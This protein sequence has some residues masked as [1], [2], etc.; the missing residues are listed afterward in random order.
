M[1]D[2][3]STAGQTR[4]LGKLKVPPRIHLGG[5]EVQSELLK[6]REFESSFKARASRDSRI[7]GKPLRKSK[8]E[9]S[10]YSPS[11]RTDLKEK[12]DYH[13]Q[14]LDEDLK[15]L[16]QQTDDKLREVEKL[17]KGLGIDVAD[18]SS[19]ESI[20]LRLEKIAKKVENGMDKH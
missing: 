2:E 15:D 13:L 5:N 16:K 17:F 11:K 14:E 7:E 12:V 4:G 6:D 3:P 10:G 18:F 8:K 19:M 9:S 20:D 1:K